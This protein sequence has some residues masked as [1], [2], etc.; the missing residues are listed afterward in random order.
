MDLSTTTLPVLPLRNGV[1]FPHMVVTITIE[2][3]EARRAIAAAET[4]GGRLLLVPRVDGDFASV[5]TIA[6]IQE[7]TQDGRAAALIAGVA[8]ARIGSGIAGANDVLWVDVAPVPDD[9]DVVKGS[10]RLTGGCQDLLQD[11][12]QV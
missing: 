9:T 12:L 8:R 7:V 4:T 2:S 1:M 6:E 3:D 10:L 11:Q 5:G